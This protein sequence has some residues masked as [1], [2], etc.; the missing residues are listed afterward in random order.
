MPGHA[1]Y[2]KNVITG[3]AQVDG[4]ILVASAMD[5]VEP[6]TR[7][8]VI[9]ARQIGDQVEVAGLGASLRTAVTGV[10]THRKTMERAVAGGNV[11]LPLRGV[12]RPQVR[13]NPGEPG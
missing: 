10:G 3:A 1:G 4:A 12:R 6:R 2:V 7:E 8:H 11:A 5:G 13:R 9:L